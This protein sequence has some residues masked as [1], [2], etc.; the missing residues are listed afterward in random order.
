MGLLCTLAQVHNLS[1]TSALF[2]FTFLELA[3]L[4]KLMFVESVV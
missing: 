2:D 4:K 3:F 1:I